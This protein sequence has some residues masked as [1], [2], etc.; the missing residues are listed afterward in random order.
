MVL[1]NVTAF[2][3]LNMLHNLVSMQKFLY[4]NN[5]WSKQNYEKCPTWPKLFFYDL[6]ET[7]EKFVKNPVNKILRLE[8]RFFNRVCE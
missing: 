5:C 4:A 1:V 6:S 2:V 7:A 3:D 8:D